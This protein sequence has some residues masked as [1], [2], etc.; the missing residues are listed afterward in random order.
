MA[1]ARP[2]YGKGQIDRAGEILAR[3]DDGFE[4]VQD[5]QDYLKAVE[6]VGNWRT[7]HSYPLQVLKMTLKRRAKSIDPTAIVSQR[8]KR[9]ASIMLKL[10]LSKAAGHY[11]NLSQMQDI[12]GCRAVMET[13]QQVRKLERKFLH[14]AR[15]NPQRGPEFSK[16]SD[17]LANPKV[18]GYRGVHL[19]YKFRSKSAQHSCYNGQRIEIQL[20]SRLQHYW[21]TAVETYSTFT[22]EALKSNIGSEDWM[23]FFALVSSAIATPRRTPLYRVASLHG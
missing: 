16:T 18:N 3:D 7:V 8:L 1:W 20:R 17:Y 11:P 22:G 5:F 4:T 13:V 2:Q 21:A 19:V 23:H 14:A 6:T 15:K 9:F 12:G 10:R